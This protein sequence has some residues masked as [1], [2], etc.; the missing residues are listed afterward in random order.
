MGAP[1]VL[2][3]TG[4]WL[5][6]LEDPVVTKDD[7]VTHVALSWDRPMRPEIVAEAIAVLSDYEGEHPRIDTVL[8]RL[9]ERVS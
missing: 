4:T 9:R 7:T 8:R 5:E 3:E 1:L 2:I 6:G